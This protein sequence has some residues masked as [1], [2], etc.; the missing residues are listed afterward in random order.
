VLSLG[1]RAFP[2]KER[3]TERERESFSDQ[4]RETEREREDKRREVG[5]GTSRVRSLLELRF[6]VPFLLAANPFFLLV[7]VVCPSTLVFHA[8]HS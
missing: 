8:F 1:E 5:T 2:I 7:L 3:E 4:E 6:R